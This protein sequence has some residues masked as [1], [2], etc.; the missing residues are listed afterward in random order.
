MGRKRHIAFFLFVL[1]LMSALVFPVASQEAYAAESDYSYDTRYGGFLGKD[2]VHDSRFDSG[3]KKH[4]GLDVSKYQGSVNWAKV[5]EAGA[6]FAFIRVGYRGYGTGNLCEDSYAAA[7]IKGALKNGLKIGVYIFSQAINVKEAVEEADFVLSLLKKYG[8]GPEDI[9]L[10]IM[11]DVEFV[12]NSS[13]GGY[14]GRLYEANLTKAQRTDMTLAFLERVEDSGYTGG[15]YGSRSALNG[16][17]KC[18]MS[19]INGKY[20]VWMA[21]YTTSKKAGYGGPYEFWQYSSTG[22][23]PGISGNVDVDVWYEKIEKPAPAEPAEPEDDPDD[24]EPVL[25]AAPPAET[26]PVETAAPAED[27]GSDTSLESSKVTGNSE[28]S[29][30]GKTTTTTAVKTTKTVKTGWQ[31]VKGK[32]YYVDP[33][34]KK[35]VTGWQTI[36]GKRYYFN[37]KGVMQTGLQKISGKR[38]YFDKNGVMQK[39][40]ETV[41]GKK[42]YFGKDGAALTRWQ[43]IN[44]KKYY[45]SSEGVMRKG[46]RNIGGKRYHFTSSGVMQTGWQKISGKWYYF[47]KSGVMARNMYI[48]GYWVDANGVRG[49]K[50]TKAIAALL[51]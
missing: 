21:A 39:G 5:A 20:S 31:T 50:R 19:K 35:N 46:W 2:L 3:Y 13:T 7:N 47:Y 8:V 4:Y 28:S 11:Y 26:T 15:L 29:S 24:P 34:T 17:I 1:M 40:W 38:Y 14:K 30:S 18:D 10:P 51:L 6:E 16:E 12:Y 25:T 48:D 33:K 32:K 49:N 23:V 36:G 37:N 44:G 27:S 45:F 43:T 22:K 9:T 41:S 42:Y